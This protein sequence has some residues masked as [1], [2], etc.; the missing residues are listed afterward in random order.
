V[1][2][3]LFQQGKQAE[4]AE[5]CHQ[6]LAGKPALAGERQRIERLLAQAETHK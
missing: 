3:V 5:A 4:A 6:A 2:E 1:A